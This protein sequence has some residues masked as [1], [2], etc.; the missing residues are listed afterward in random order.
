MTWLI[1]N[2]VIKNRRISISRYRFPVFILV[3]FLENNPPPPPP[4]F[5]ETLLEFSWSYSSW[6]H[7]T[8]KQYIAKEFEIISNERTTENRVQV[9]AKGKDTGKE[10]RS[11]L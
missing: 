8:L 11:W 1:N 4:R 9:E 3:A 5:V 10:V 6:F 7:F 2:E